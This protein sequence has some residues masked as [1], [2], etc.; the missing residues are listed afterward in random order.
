M[1]VMIDRAKPR[2]GESVQYLAPSPDP[3]AGGLKCFAAIVTYVNADETV[4]LVAFARSGQ[5]MFRKGIRWAHD[6]VDF[7]VTY[8]GYARPI[9]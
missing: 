9:Q 7:D 6:T 8:A 5:T 2:I 1:S 3:M 4:D